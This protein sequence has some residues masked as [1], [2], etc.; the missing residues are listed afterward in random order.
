M[1]PIMFVELKDH[2]DT[3]LSMTSLS[4]EEFRQMVP[5]FGSIWSKAHAVDGRPPA[6]KSMQDRLL[7]IL[8]Y[9][10]CHPLQQVLGYLFGLSQERASELIDEYT[11]ILLEMVRVYGLA[12]ERISEELKKSLNKLQHRITSSTGP[13][14]P[15][16]DP[17]TRK[18]R[19]TSTVEKATSTLSRTT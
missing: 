16:K 3:F 17:K 18:S 11:D 5:M 19:K 1:P 7:F 4:V 15:S 8:F 13:S 6:I 9:F 10:K 2:P 14:G 12:P